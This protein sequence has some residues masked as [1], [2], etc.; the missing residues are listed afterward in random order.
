MNSIVAEKK[1]IESRLGVP[2]DSLSQ[3]YLRAETALNSTSVIPFYLQKGQVSAP[4]VTENLLQLNDQFVITH[5]SIGIRT[6]A[7]DT[8]TDLLQLKSQV[9][10]WEDP[11]IFSGTN[12]VNV[13]ALWNAKF[14]MT[15]NRK[16]YLPAFPMRAFRR[17]GT[18]QSSNYLKTGG[19]TTTPVATYTGMGGANESS[20]G[21]YGFYPMEPTLLDG[22][23]TLDININLGTSVSF[24]DSSEISYAV[25]EAR[26]YL[27]VN[28]KD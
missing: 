20:N 24:D 14:S 3:S 12:R 21:L 5:L 18:A 13:A 16:E 26:G 17:V 2:Y 4:L 25:F 28:V 22:R 27:V 23:Q 10:N 9:Q 11:N 8:A 7:S 15:I 6:I 1:F 19:T